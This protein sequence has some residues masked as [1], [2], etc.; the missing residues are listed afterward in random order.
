VEGVNLQADA[1]VAIY[2]LT[3]KSATSLASRVFRCRAV[4]QPRLTGPP[5]SRKSYAPPGWVGLGKFSV[6]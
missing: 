3:A 1:N 4:R 6:G 2:R 5:R